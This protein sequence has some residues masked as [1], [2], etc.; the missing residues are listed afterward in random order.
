MFRVG[1]VLEWVY[2]S[3]VSTAEKAR[4]GAKRPLGEWTPSVQQAYQ[5]LVEM[6]RDQ[7]EWNTRYKNA[8]SLLK[9]LT[10]VR[11]RTTAFAKQHGI[12]IPGTA[13]AREGGTVADTLPDSI[14]ESVLLRES[15][16]TQA[17]LHILRYEHLLA[18]NQL[19]TLRTEL[20]QGEPEFERLKRELESAKSLART[21]DKDRQRPKVN[22]TML[23]DH[24]E[25]QSAFRE[26][27][28]RLQ[29]MYDKRQRT[30][31][32][33][34]RRETEITQLDNWFKNVTQLR[35]RLLNAIGDD[36][37]P[38]DD[39]AL[40]KARAAF[41]KDF[42]KQLYS[43]LD[44]Q[45]F[46]NRIRAELKTVE[47]RLEDGAVV[48][49]HLEMFLINVACDDPGAAIGTSVILPLLQERLDKEAMQFSM[50]RASEAMDALLKM[51]EEKKALKAKKELKRKSSKCIANA[52]PEETAM[53]DDT[54]EESGHEPEPVVESSES[55]KTEEEPPKLGQMPT[56]DPVLVQ[57]SMV[58]R[59]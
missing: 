32:E 27:G 51:E 59:K 8:K 39:A 45:T 4:D 58:T 11:K 15:L 2:G 34:V 21:N 3:I 16:L 22:E 36:E 35:G 19:K 26:Q 24:L 41:H 7:A 20:M 46:C 12:V 57:Q 40:S 47:K 29:G 38:A 10:A 42:K 9:D 13:A 43:D 28:A 30:E 6:L 1:L 56:E 44:E 25:V 17:K 23:E 14:I 37:K 49:Q 52:E 53:E 5:N 50:K 33:M 18:R 31:L 48:L 54:A 55:S